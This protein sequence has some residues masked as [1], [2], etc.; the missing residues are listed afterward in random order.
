LVPALAGTIGII[1]M[2]SAV[3]MSWAD[4][5]TAAWDHVN[6]GKEF[7]IEVARVE[8]LIPALLFCVL[9]S[10]F[11]NPR[12]NLAGNHGPMIPLIG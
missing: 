5:L 8:M 9:A 10:G 6:L 2:Y 4:G 3:M 12:A 11:I 1:A 7:A